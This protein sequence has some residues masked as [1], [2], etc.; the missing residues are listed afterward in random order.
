MLMFLEQ[1][2]VSLYH[3]DVC[4]TELAHYKFLLIP[5]SGALSDQVDSA[6]QNR[7]VISLHLILNS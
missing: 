4:L 2:L 5:G 7:T 6:L 1:I 3:H